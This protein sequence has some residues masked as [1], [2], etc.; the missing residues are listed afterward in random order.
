[1]APH[2]HV[3]LGHEYI[4]GLT[5]QLSDGPRICELMCSGFFGA[6]HG[7]WT[8]RIFCRWIMLLLTWGKDDCLESG[9]AEVVEF[10]E[11]IFEFSVVFHLMHIDAR[12][13]AGLDSDC[14]PRMDGDWIV[15]HWKGFKPTILWGMCRD[16]STLEVRAKLADLGLASFVR[17]KV[18]WEGEAYSYC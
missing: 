8:W 5:W 4:K 1:M 2:L 10:R 3:T 7:I 15:S 16:I 17:G 6:P 18:A 13:A 14:W 12:H 11:A 9:S